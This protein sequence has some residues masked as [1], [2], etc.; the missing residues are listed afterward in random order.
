MAQ[1]P[2]YRYARWIAIST[3]DD[4]NGL[5][6]DGFR[7]L[8]DGDPLERFVEQFRQS[9]AED[10]TDATLDADVNLYLADD[11]L[12]KMDRATMAHSLEARSPFLDHVLMEFVATLP[13]QLKLSG[14][15]KKRV[16]KQSLRGVLPDAVLDRPKMGFG[17]PIDAWFRKDLREM[18]HDV[19]LSSKAKQRGYFRPGAVERLLAE[20]CSQETDYAAMLWDLLVLEL[21]HRAFID[22][23]SGHLRRV[24]GSA[25]GA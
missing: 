18:A 4:R 3:A 25:V 6:A 22:D 23:S 2:E 9:D 13:P 16:L 11:L 21:W 15:E 24:S 17:A 5:Y 19:L 12:V 8:L 7:H 10:W 14:S 1:T 20:H